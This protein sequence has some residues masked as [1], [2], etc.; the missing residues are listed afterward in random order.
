VN[1]R[2]EDSLQRGIEYFRQ[3]IEKDPAYP[4]AHVGLADAYNLLG[5]FS[6]R[7]PRE[8]FPRARAAAQR[9]LEIDADTAEAHV[10]LA[11]VSFYHDWSW[12][13]AEASFRRG[14]ELDPGYAQGY[15]WSANLHSARGRFEEALATVGR[16]LALDPLSLALNSAS[17]WVLYF[18]RRH[19]DSLAN[20]G[21]ALEMEPTFAPALLYRSWTHLALERTA[22]AIDDLERAARSSGM[23]AIT[24]P[25]LAYAHARTGDTVAARARLEAVHASRTRRH[26][27]AYL[28]ALA[29]DAL[30]ERETAFEWMARAVEERDHWLVFI[31]VDPR[32]DPLR[33]DPRFEAIRRALSL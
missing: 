20:L 5:F 22:E 2:T 31:D 14:L 8:V 15:L 1:R 32:F 3:A 12:K 24:D 18:Q 7:E 10:S 13:E 11:Y 26:V 33:T 9:A 29:H 28:I 4:M 30:G 17:G 6:Y 25:T 16:G 27:P 23:T 19:E 21:R